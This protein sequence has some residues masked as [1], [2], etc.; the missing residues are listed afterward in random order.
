MAIWLKTYRF[1]FFLTALLSIAVAVMI[2]VT[3]K[4]KAKKAK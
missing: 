4:D 1:E 2:E 3:H